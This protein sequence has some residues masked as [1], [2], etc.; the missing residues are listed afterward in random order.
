MK[1]TIYLTF[2][3]TLTTQAL[4]AQSTIEKDINVSRI[5]IEVVDDHPEIYQENESLLRH[6]DSSTGILTDAHYTGHEVNR[7]SLS[8]QGSLD[9]TNL[10]EVSSFDLQYQFKADNYTNTWWAVQFKSTSAEY[11]AIAD[12][13]TNTS[14]HPDSDANSLR[15]ENIQTINSLGVGAGYRFKL[16]F[17][18]NESERFFEH[19]TAFLTYNSALDATTDRAYQGWGYNADYSLLYRSGNSLYYGLKFSYNLAAVIRGA[20]SDED[21]PDRSLVYGWTN[22]GLEIG[23]YY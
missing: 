15:S 17:A 23:Y 3:V 4:W 11:E 19:I 6:K 8:Y 9:Y 22:M 14:G 21:K 2:F 10:N 5:P 7:L 16:L 13:L 18:F 20:I 1:K 12:E